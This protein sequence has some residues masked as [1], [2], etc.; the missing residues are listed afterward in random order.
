MSY[1]PRGKVKTLID[2]MDADPQREWTAADAAEVMRTTNGGVHAF[3]ARALEAKQLY[4]SHSNGRTVFSRKPFT[5]ASCVSRL[6]AVP[7]TST[8][9]KPPEMVC[10]RPTAG[11]PAPAARSHDTVDGLAPDAPRIYPDESREDALTKMAA[12]G[13]A[14]EAQERCEPAGAAPAPAEAAPALTDASSP[15]PAGASAEEEAPHEQPLTW[16]IWDDGDVDLFGLVEL[17]NGGYR[18]QA[19]DVARL[20]RML[21]WL[22][23]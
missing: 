11:T 16:S 2:A 14:R 3:V 17:E 4:R 8:G 12:A 10:T 1:E 19:K 18:I 13:A 5:E 22:P 20:R 15:E 23:A 7:T 21:A 6:P 9:W